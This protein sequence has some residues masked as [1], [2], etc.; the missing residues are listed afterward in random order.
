[1]R[2]LLLCIMVMAVML[3][4]FPTYSMA[5]EQKD[6]VVMTDA[7]GER[8]ACIAVIMQG[9]TYDAADCV[10]FE[11]AIEASG[12]SYISFTRYGWVEDQSFLAWDSQRVT[13]ARLQTMR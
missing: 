5:Q 7:N 3:S 8:A 4:I 13:E 9:N 1:M 6:A 12:N 10:A 11:N 2:K